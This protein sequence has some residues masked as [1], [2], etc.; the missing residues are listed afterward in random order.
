MYFFFF[1]AEDGIR[2][3]KVT[4]VQTC[5]LPISAAPHEP[6]P[7]ARRCGS[8]ARRRRAPA[9]RLAPFPGPSRRRRHARRDVRRRAQ[10][11]PQ[12]DPGSEALA[13]RPRRPGG[14]LLARSLGGGEAGDPVNRS[15]TPRGHVAREPRVAPRLLQLGV[16]ELATLLTACAPPSPYR[17][18]EHTS[19]LQ[20]PCKLL[21]RLL[22]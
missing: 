1:Q 8:D 10:V 21:C 5:A 22:L 6:R 12:L 13:A 19:E 18:E 4:G 9:W 15:T 17:S 2:D 20:S 7:G 16:V 3:Y 14:R 11:H